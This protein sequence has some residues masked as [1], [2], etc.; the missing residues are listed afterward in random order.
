M[1]SGVATWLDVRGVHSKTF[2][3]YNFNSASG[4]VSATIEGEYLQLKFDMSGSPMFW[5][6][7]QIRI[8]ASGTAD[9]K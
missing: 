6:Q 4:R 8:D 9:K 1:I 5:R 3:P 2:G 7:G